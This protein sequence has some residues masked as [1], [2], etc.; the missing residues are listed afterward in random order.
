MQ[1]TGTSGESLQSQFQ[2]LQAEDVRRRIVEQDQSVVALQRRCERGA[3][4][5]PIDAVVR[6]GTQLPDHQ[7]GIGGIIFKKQDA[8]R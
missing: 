4:T 7:F 1:T 3:I 2:R 8:D 6:P 5:D